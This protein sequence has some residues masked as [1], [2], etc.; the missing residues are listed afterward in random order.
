MHGDWLDLF[1][2]WMGLLDT[3]AADGITDYLLANYVL[4]SIR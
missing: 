3:K 4:L 1:I 2:D